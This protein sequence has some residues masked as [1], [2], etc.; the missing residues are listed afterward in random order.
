METTRSYDTPASL[1]NAAMGGV[2]TP[3]LSFN[4]TG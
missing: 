1:T 2:I 4:F 3:T